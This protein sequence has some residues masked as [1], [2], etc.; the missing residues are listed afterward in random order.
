MGNLIGGFTD[1]VSGKLG[2]DGPFKKLEEFGKLQIDG[3]RVKKNAEAM[4]AFGDAMSKYKGTDQ[5]MWSTLSEGVAGFFEIE[6]PYSKMQKFAEIDLGENGAKRVKQNAQAFVYF[7]QALSEFKGGGELKNAADNI[8]GGI[9]KMFGGDDVMGKFVKFTKLD[10]D[11]DKALKL[12]QAFAAYTSAIGM[13]RSGGGGAPA[14][15]GGGAPAGGAGGAGGAP[16]TAASSAKTA[17]PAA[18]AGG[19]ASGSGASGGGESGGIFSKIGAALGFGGGDKGAGGGKDTSGAGTEQAPTKTARATGG[20][21][22]M[23]EQDAKEMTKRHEGVRFEPYKDSL[24]LWT[25]GVGHLIGDGKSLPSEWNRTFSEKEVMDLYDK[26]YEKHKKQA[27]SNVPGF[28]KYDSVGQAALIDLTFN[29]GPGWPRKFPNTSKKLAAGDTEGAAAGLT[30]SLWYQQVKSRGP[31]IV[32]M[33]RNS[34]VSARDGGLATGPETGYPATLHGNEMI[35]PLDPKSIL[36][37]MGKKSMSEI[38]TQIQEKAGQIQ[39][40]DPEIFKELASINQSMMDMMATKLDAVI[41][42]LD[43]SNNT[44]S[45]ILKYSKA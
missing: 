10:V 26:D 23:S 29:M 45:K 36:A 2:I 37:E 25:V 8:V 9:V 40:S 20:G 31:T 11:P 3:D 28:A 19:G 18:A 1:K 27:Q 5:S 30:D 17:A 35:T 6:P 41:D 32:E 15:T 38:S 39:S 13:A 12:G 16:A 42:K 14:R 33:V 7:S 21:G 4:A 34:K 22:S 24:G 44:Q 43:S